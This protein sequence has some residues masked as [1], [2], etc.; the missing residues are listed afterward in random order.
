MELAYIIPT[1][2]MWSQPKVVHVIGDLILP[3]TDYSLLIPEWEREGGSQKQ[4]M[5]I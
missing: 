2:L 1:P 5:K 3:E 4:R